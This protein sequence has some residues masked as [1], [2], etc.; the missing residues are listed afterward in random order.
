M[1]NEENKKA[2]ERSCLDKTREFRHFARS[3]TKNILGYLCGEVIESERPDFIIQSSIG[4]I[5]VEHF[6][7]DT[8]LGK[9][10]AARSR[11]R[12]SEIQR[13]FD[14]Y[15]DSLDGNEDNALNDIQ[16]IVQ[17]DLDAVQRFNYLDFI[18]EF[19]RISLDHSKG[20]GG[21]IKTNRNLDKIIFMVE[22]NIAWDK[23]I[24]I[25]GFYRSEIIKGRRF[26]VTKDMIDIMREIP[27]QVDYILLSVMHEHYKKTPLVVYAFDKKKLNQSISAQF[28]QIYRRFTYDMELMPNKAKLRLCLDDKE[29]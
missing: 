7:I 8:L 17:A 1:K 4:Y 2:I 26:P 22:V 25:D 3:Y 19:K 27:E 18:K 5:G 14:K 10:R 13:T 21:Y 16:G 9:K 24:G 12:K 29:Y 11:I 15:H 28:I 6:L 23:M 20:V